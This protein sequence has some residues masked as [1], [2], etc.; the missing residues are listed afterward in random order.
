MKT[1]SE[2]AMSVYG[3]SLYNT[4]DIIREYALSIVQACVDNLEADPNPDEPG[5]W[6]VSRPSIE[7]VKK[8]IK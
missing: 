5:E 7:D 8:L 4:E 3:N 2:V 1:V 6:A